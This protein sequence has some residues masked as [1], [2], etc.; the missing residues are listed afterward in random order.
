MEKMWILNDFS[1]LNYLF[2][3]TIPLLLFFSVY[4][5]VKYLSTMGE[6]LL[7]KM[8]GGRISP[9]DFEKNMVYLFQMQ[10]TSKAPNSSPNCLKVESFL[11]YHQIPFVVS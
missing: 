1:D 2:L 11:K 9:K 6:I 8:E 3:L 4:L 5:V 10:C 7:M